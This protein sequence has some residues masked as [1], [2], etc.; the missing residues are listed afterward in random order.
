MRACTVPLNLSGFIYLGLYISGACK[1][2]TKINT[3]L[4]GM[5]RFYYTF[6]RDVKYDSFSRAAKFSG[7]MPLLRV[8]LSGVPYV[9]VWFMNVETAQIPQGALNWATC[10]MT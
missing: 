1:C 9:T 4:T 2:Y 8:S 7:F 3:L 6:S 10:Y 5:L